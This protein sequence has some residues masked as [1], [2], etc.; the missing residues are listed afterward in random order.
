[1]FTLLSIKKILFSIAVL[2]SGAVGVHPAPVVPQPVVLAPEVKQAIDQY[3]SVKVPAKP[4]TLGAAPSPAALNT[5]NLAGSGVSSSASSIT[6]TSLTI[7]QT[8]QRITTSNLV[9]GAGDRFY[10]TLE[11]G[12]AT[13][14]E[15]TGC[16]T[17]TQNSN[18]TATLSGCSRGLLPVYPYT[19]S[20]T[21]AFTHAGG[22][23][24]I[25]GDA[26]QLFNDLV[27]YIAS[28]SYSGTVD[29]S[30]TVKGVVEQASA[31]EAEHHAQVG[32]GNTSCR[33]QRTAS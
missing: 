10:V 11:P 31:S 7:K 24:V 17:V 33:A 4:V 27:N 14:Q 20:T 30:L 28:T 16:T 18:N 22:S 19:A 23:Q 2:V 8:G 25:F 26:P 6:L 29:A 15:I 12:S 1:M 21:M 32:S 3:I 13:K 5:Y 9:Q